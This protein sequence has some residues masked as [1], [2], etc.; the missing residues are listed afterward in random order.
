MTLG[1]CPWIALHRTPCCTIVLVAVGLPGVRVGW[2]RPGER[3]RLKV[4][5]NSV[6][7][8]GRPRRRST[9]GTARIVRVVSL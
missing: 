1:V 2:A 8:V 6:T 7:S 4:R 5:R 9:H 3:E